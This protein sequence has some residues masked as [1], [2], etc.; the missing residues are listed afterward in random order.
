[1]FYFITGT[2]KLVSTQGKVFLVATQRWFFLTAG[3]GR[4]KGGWVCRGN[5]M[6]DVRTEMRRSYLVGEVRLLR[7]GRWPGELQSQK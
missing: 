3:R 4:G 1:M 7:G 2:G 5:W 6:D